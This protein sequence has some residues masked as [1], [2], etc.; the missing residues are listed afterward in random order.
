LAKTVI[1][2]NPM[3]T[4]VTQAMQAP[5]LDG[6]ILMKGT[7]LSPGD[8]LYTLP[9]N[10]TSG[11]ANIEA[12]VTLL[13]NKLNSTSGDILVFGYSEGC[14]IAYMWLR[15][16]G[17]TT[18]INPDNLSFLLIANAERKY[19]GFA[20]QQSNYDAVGDTA[21][22]PTTVPYQVLDIA[23]Q[24]DGVAD[25]P[26][27]NGLLE[28][29]NSIAA[30]TTS[31][32][33][34]YTTAMSA[35]LAILSN[36]AQ[37]TAVMNAV[38]GMVYIHNLGYESVTVA[39]PTN[40]QYVD[41]STPNVTYIWAP[42]YPVP[43][44]GI[45][46]SATFP[47]SDQQYRTI[48]ET[49][50]DRPVSIPMPDYAASAGW[51][52]EPFPIQPT[53]PPVV[54]WWATLR[55]SCAINVVPSIAAHAGQPNGVS[56][57]VT[58]TVTAVAN[59]THIANVSETI[60][61][62]VSVTG[63]K[64]V[65]GSNAISVTPTVS[66]TAQLI[67]PVSCAISV[68]PVV[69]AAARDELSVAITVTPSVNVSAQL[70]G[71]QVASA[72]TATPSV[73]TAAAVIK[74]ATTSVTV[75]PS[76][77][78]SANMM[79]FGS[80]PISV[81]PSV[82]A[83][84]GVILP[85]SASV[86]V[87]PAVSPSMA[88]AV[89]TSV[90]VT[91]SVAVSAVVFKGAQVA[92]D[93]TPTVSASS[94]L[95]VVGSV[96]VE[97][98]PSVAASAV[99]VGSSAIT[100]DPAVSVSAESVVS[101]AVTVTPS[102]SASAV[103]TKFGSVA[104]TA[105]PSVS[106]SG[107]VTEFGS[108]AITV[109]PSVSAVAELI[110]P[111]SVAVSATPSV[112]VSGVKGVASSVAITA[113]PS[114]SV[115]GSVLSGDAFDAVGA[116]LIATSFSTTGSWSH[117]ATAGAYVFA[118]IADTNSSEGAGVTPSSVKYGSTSMTSLA[119]GISDGQGGEFFVYGLAN[120]AGGAQT[121][122]VTTGS[123]ALFVANSISFTGVTSVGTPATVNSTSQSVS[124]GSGKLIVQ[125]FEDVVNDGLSSPTG[126]TLRSTVKTGSFVG[127]YISTATATTTF[128]VSDGGSNPGGIAV[129]LS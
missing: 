32:P 22:L 3:G 103:V 13:N 53:P 124:L 85:A 71:F 114:V 87:T 119:S 76:V 58:P 30:P 91:P 7:I 1:L 104:V 19:G 108:T 99:A 90:S 75:T 106:A 20:Y 66:A 50:Y 65:V 72:I 47:Q 98:V 4:D 117:T 84:A 28:E 35:G 40:V 45:P 48:V 31:T 16:Y 61:P 12:G 110:L 38:A 122:T 63:V 121:V 109:T 54:G 81:T 93:V 46:G 105:T 68:T 18:P 123:S 95:T 69:S 39:N 125:A 129:I 60:T 100:V 43:L 42:T 37:T 77:S 11:V 92:V 33:N 107:V 70:A 83:S 112:S 64:G 67:L 113:T 8:T 116:G 96:P 59:I 102:V 88:A 44:L 26:T 128:T 29:Y 49:C 21:G 9:Y 56:I 127:L 15:N 126:G 82:A 55:V 73:S 2:L 14:Q 5:G 86:S 89:S 101:S 23:C 51:S 111:A 57:V 52:V 62:V 118:F 94:L 41:P 27:A 25:F 80:V 79:A 34:P 78:A 120:V 24:Y 74:P 115:A 6:L 97:V 17:T 10:N 36:S